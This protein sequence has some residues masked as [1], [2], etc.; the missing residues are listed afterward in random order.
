VHIVMSEFIFGYLEKGLIDVEGNDERL[1]QLQTSSQKLSDRFVELPAELLVFLREALVEKGT[2][3]SPR[4]DGFIEVVRETWPTFVAVESG[5]QIPILI[6]VGWEAVKLA[7]A[8]KPELARLVWYGTINIVSSFGVAKV[9]EPAVPFIQQ[10]G[11]AVETEAVEL[12]SPFA[13]VANKKVRTVEAPA[14]P[15]D[16]TLGLQKAA[17]R[18]AADNATALEGGNPNAVAQLGPW[19]GH[20]A[21]QSASTIDEAMKAY[22][23]A[24]VES[25]QVPF[26]DLKNKYDALKRDLVKAHQ[27]QSR[28]TELL[29]L[30]ESKYSPRIG[31]GYN[32]ISPREAILMLA[33]DI[34]EIAKGSSPKSVE[35]FLAQVAGT[36]VK[37]KGV[38]VEA[39]VKEIAKSTSLSKLS[40]RLFEE[41]KSDYMGILEFVGRLKSQEVT[42]ADLENRTGFAKT[43]NLS[44]GE[45]AR[46]IFREIKCCECLRGD[47]WN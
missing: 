18:V 25:V 13:S 33:Y 28:R 45:L 30:A 14:T 1:T 16:M 4:L 24:I 40:P 36:V 6:A 35:Y 5:K 9:S 32:D 23:D 22:G 37:G 20:F 12:W 2:G 41:V 3:E 38:K 7:V 42:L 8:V 31:L 46:L 15:V 34:A 11:V 43:T 39:F 10:Q 19:A 27:S 47:L 44:S 21:E 17:S 29:W 26:S